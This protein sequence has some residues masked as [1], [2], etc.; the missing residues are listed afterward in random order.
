MCNVTLRRPLQ[1]LAW[2]GP[3]PVSPCLMLMPA[4]PL[5]HSYGFAPPP[6]TNPHDGVKLR[7]SLWEDDPAHAWKAAALARHGF[8]PSQLF[9]LRMQAAPWE[10]MH[11]AGMCVAQV[12]SA[13]EVNSLAGRLFQ[14]DD[15]PRELQPVALEAVICA[16]QAAQQ[17]YP[18]SLDADRAELEALEQQQQRG[19]AGS[20][21]G[22]GGATAA[23]SRRQQVLQVLIYERQVRGW[24]GVEHPTGGMVAVECAAPACRSVVMQAACSACC[25]EA[26]LQL[27]ESYVPPEPR[28]PNRSLQVLARTIFI[29]QQELRDLKRTARA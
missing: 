13:A 10:L 23:P 21:G 25:L 19:T 1:A 16:C 4:L 2:P 28:F 6:A 17:A 15:F 7:L 26:M 14:Q 18:S 29:L 11:F 27:A 22:G 5:T 20:S 9:P 8:A 12:G 24:G 3:A